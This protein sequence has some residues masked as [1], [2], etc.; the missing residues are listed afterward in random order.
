MSDPTPPPTPPET[1]PAPPALT[2]A[3]SMLVA[4]QLYEP[5]VKRMGTL[6]W[7]LI[8]A[9]GNGD[10]SLW[11]PL[12]TM[13]R[14][15]ADMQWAKAQ[16]PA[17]RRG[18]LALLRLVQFTLTTYAGQAA[19]FADQ[20]E[21]YYALPPGHGAPFPERPQFRAPETAAVYAQVDALLP[22]PE[23]DAHVG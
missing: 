6:V 4:Q 13:D 15:L 22:K 18:C 12:A 5:T 23:G 8:Q 17:D 14:A 19:A 11:A 3:D 1:E 20:L 21:R 2:D 7:T 9:T 10:F 16:T